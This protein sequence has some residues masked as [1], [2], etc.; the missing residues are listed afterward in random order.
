MRIEQRPSRQSAAAI[1][2][3][4]PWRPLLVASKG[5]RALPGLI[6]VTETDEG[7]EAWRVVGRDGDEYVV[8]DELDGEHA[9]VV[10]TRWPNVDEDGWLIFAE[11]TEECSFDAA[12]LEARMNRWRRRLGQVE[13]RLRISDALLVRQAE[14]GPEGAVMLDVSEAAREAAKVALYSAAAPS[15]RRPPLRE[16]PQRGEPPLRQGH[17]A[18]P[19]I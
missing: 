19:V 15:R 18:P 8:V 12:D 4:A 10:S 1:G 7:D 14:E 16:G 17:V 13:R 11:E 9:V 6:E 2:A 3:T 5:Q